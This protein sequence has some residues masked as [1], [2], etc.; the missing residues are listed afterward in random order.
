MLLVVG[1]DVTA[2]SVFTGNGSLLRAAG[3]RHH[4]I[5]LVS[6]IIRVYWLHVDTQRV[7]EGLLT[8]ARSLEVLRHHKFVHAVTRKR[9]RLCYHVQTAA[10][11]LYDFAITF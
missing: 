2:I 8:A 5:V 1:V 11:N 10:I 9:Y 6:A 4:A 7:N 3:R